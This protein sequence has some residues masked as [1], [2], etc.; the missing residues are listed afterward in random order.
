MGSPEWGSDPR[1]AT[2]PDRVANWDA[3]H[4]LMSEWSRQYDKQPIA[5]MAQA[6]RVPSFPL[7]EAAEQLASAQLAHRGFWREIEI[8][9]RAVKAPGPPF[10]LARLKSAESETPP[11]ALPRIGPARAERRPIAAAA[12]RR[13]GARF[14]LGHRRPDRD[15]LSRGDGRRGHQGR[16]A[17]PRRS[18]PRLRTAHGSRP[19]QARHRA[20]PEK[21][22]GDRRRAPP[23]GEIAMCWSRISRPGSWTGSV[24]AP[25]RCG[26]SIP[27]LI[28]VSA[29]GLGRT[30]PEARAVAYGTLLQCYAGFA[31]LNRHPEIPPRVGMAWLDPMCGLMLAFVTAAALWRRRRGGEVARIDFSMLE[32]MLWTMAEPLLTAQLGDAAAAGRQPFGAPRAAWRLSL[33]RRDDWIAIAVTEDEKLAGAVRDRPGAGAARRAWPARAHESGGARSTRRLPPGRARFGGSGRRGIDPGRRPGRRARRLARS[34]RQPASARARFLGP[35]WRRR[36]P[37]LPWRASFGRASGPAPGLGADTDAV[38]REIANLCP[39]DIA[40]LRQS[41]AFG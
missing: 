24:S 26:R 27:D 10:G 41:G 19:G 28:Y 6:A 17:G 11:P 33:R 22:R 15:A 35:A 23:G 2:K 30:G 16:G 3:L 25:R 18:G 40:A 31:G 21:T 4:A 39:E 20:R 32:A 12:R 5:D 14:Q 34:G 7:R 8:G 37:G 29:S 9:G 36:L 13:P 1:F 38:L